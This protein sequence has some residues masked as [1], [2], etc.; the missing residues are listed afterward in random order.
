MK[1]CKIILQFLTDY[2]CKFFCNFLHA[3]M[4][5]SVQFFKNS[6]STLHFYTNLSTSSLHPFIQLSSIHHP[7]NHTPTLSH[8]TFISPIII[9]IQ[10]NT[11]QIYYRVVT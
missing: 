9:P 10:H 2:K 6:H 8:L 5:N 3:K 4:G 11:A 1:N 7:T